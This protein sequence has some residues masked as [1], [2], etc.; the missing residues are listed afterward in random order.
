MS[1]SHRIVRPLVVA[2]ALLLAA[3]A[4]AQPPEVKPVSP[5]QFAT[6]LAALRGRVVMLNVWA[7]WCAPCLKEIPDL[8]AVEA[9]LR[10]EGFVLLGLSIDDAADAAQVAGFRQDHFPAFHTLQR[11]ANDADAL[12]SVVDQA[13][14]EVVPTT[15]LLAR[16]G[17][18]VRRIQGKLTRAAFLQA[19]REALGG[20]S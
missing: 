16:D 3:G 2:A 1:W 6:E 10:D 8:L 18:V 19:A 13:W 9:E 17:R 14:N 5:A 11:D 15:Y 12:V 20:G 4:G 7:T